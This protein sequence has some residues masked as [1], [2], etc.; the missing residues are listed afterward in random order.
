MILEYV[1]GEEMSILEK[2]IALYEK[3]N[4]KCGSSEDELAIDIHPVME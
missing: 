1:R 2:A 3:W 4:K